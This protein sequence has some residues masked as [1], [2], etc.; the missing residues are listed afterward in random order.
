M[1]TQ[2]PNK[3]SEERRA[4]AIAVMADPNVALVMSIAN[5]RI[6][7]LEPRAASI[8]DEKRVIRGEITGDELRQEWLSESASR[9]K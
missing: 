7:G 6:E 4:K 9:S 1:T 5:S 8:E 2:T 3:F